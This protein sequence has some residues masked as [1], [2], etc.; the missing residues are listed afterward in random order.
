MSFSAQHPFTRV[1]KVIAPAQS[2]DDYS[3]SSAS[4]GDQGVAVFPTVGIQG[5]KN[6]DPEDQ[7]QSDPENQGDLEEPRQ[8][9][10]KEKPEERRFASKFLENHQVVALFTQ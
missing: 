7:P 6:L 9:E 1:E 4:P 10:T 8:T 5:D 2:R 3:S